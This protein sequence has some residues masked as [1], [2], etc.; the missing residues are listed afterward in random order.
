MS[1]KRIGPNKGPNN[2]AETSVRRSRRFSKNSLANTVS[3]VRTSVHPF[4]AAKNLKERLFQG[5]SAAAFADL[6]HRGVGEYPAVTYD[7]HTIAE[8]SDLL[9]HMRGKQHTAPLRLQGEQHLA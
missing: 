9:H 2:N 7:H 8:R 4:G 5:C 6:L 1:P 3:S